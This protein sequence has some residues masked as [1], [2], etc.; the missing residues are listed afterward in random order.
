M[1]RRGIPAAVDHCAEKRTESV[2]VFF[3]EGKPAGIRFPNANRALAAVRDQLF[4]EFAKSQHFKQVLRGGGVLARPPCFDPVVGVEAVS[5]VKQ[6]AAA[7]DP[8][9]KREVHVRVFR[10]QIFVA[11]D[12][13]FVIVQIPGISAHVVQQYGTDLRSVF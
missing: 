11:C 13:H 6:N 12:Q 4:P 2:G 5:D 8:F 10:L 3:G 7:L 9:R 1:R